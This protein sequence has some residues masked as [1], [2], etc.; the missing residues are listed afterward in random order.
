MKAETTVF[1]NLVMELGLYDQ[2]SKLLNSFNRLLNDVMNLKLQPESATW[3]H[4]QVTTRLCVLEAQ[5][6]EDRITTS[7]HGI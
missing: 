4:K 7:S 2:D 3:G 6:L 1:M 5:S